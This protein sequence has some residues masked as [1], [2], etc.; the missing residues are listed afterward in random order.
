MD[1]VTDDAALDEEGIQDLREAAQE[2]AR[3]VVSDAVTKAL[4]DFGG[5]L[6]DLQRISGIQPASLS[7]LARGQNVQ[8]GTV[9][10]LAQIALA[11]DKSLHIS[12]D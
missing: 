11:L 1:S 6:R 10:S 3:A 2:I 5:S 12:F 7:K 9:A 8:G 4:A